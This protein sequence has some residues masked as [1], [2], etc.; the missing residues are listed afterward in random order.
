MRTFILILS[1]GVLLASCGKKAQTAATPD[2]RAADSVKA[3]LKGHLN[4]PASY[5]PETFGKL[6]KNFSSYMN[7]DNYY[8]YSNWIAR[9][10]EQ[11]DKKDSAAV[12]QERK[13]SGFY[14]K[15]FREGMRKM[16]SLKKN[17]KSSF[18]GYKIT[19]SYRAKN[20]AGSIEPQQAV[21]TLDTAF[22]VLKMDKAG[23]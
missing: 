19:H 21:F 11:S 3:Y 8:T 15:M 2:A 1:A 22:S 12:Y 10:K 6:E 9:T 13:R 20:T 5:Q 14:D 17:Y 7:D 16:D 4:D 18:M 23:K